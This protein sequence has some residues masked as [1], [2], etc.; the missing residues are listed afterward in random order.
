MP[1]HGIFGIVIGHCVREFLRS[2]PGWLSEHDDRLRVMAF[3]RSNMGLYLE[4][5]FSADVISTAGAVN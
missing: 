4:M 3:Q 1:C 2:M 5:E